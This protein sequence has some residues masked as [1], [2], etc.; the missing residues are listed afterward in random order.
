MR[1]RIYGLMLSFWCCAAVASAAQWANLFEARVAVADQSEAARIEALPKALER[2]L[3][4]VTGRRQLGDEGP[5]QA[6]LA[7]AGD[8]VER[9][10]YERVVSD[11]DGLM[12]V[13]EYDLRVEMD[14]NA[15]TRAI[16]ETGLPFWGKQRPTVLVWLAISTPAQRWVVAADANDSMQAAL[17]RVSEQRGVPLVLPLWDLQDRASLGFVDLAGGFVAPIREATVRYGADVVAIVYAQSQGNDFWRLRWVLDGLGERGTWEQSGNHLEY[18]IRNGLQEIVDRLAGQLAVAAQ[19]TSQQGIRLTVSGIESLEQW[20]RVERFLAEADVVQRYAVQRL[21]GD[22]VAFEVI[23]PGGRN[24]L[25]RIIELGDVLV[26]VAGAAPTGES[27]Q[28]L[29]CRLAQ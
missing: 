17:E 26:P 1:R 25:L 16:T 6:L 5:V 20:F 18:L 10:R 24:A 8:F 2:V 9:Y 21:H 23:V 29:Y 14:A 27:G 4:R 15:L 28:E 19:T 11:A 12:G 7:R 13:A 22:E 3:V